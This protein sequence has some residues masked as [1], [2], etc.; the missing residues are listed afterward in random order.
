MLL[1]F[2][3]LKTFV[4]FTVNGIADIVALGIRRAVDVFGLLGAVGIFLGFCLDTSFNCGVALQNYL[5]RRPNFSREVQ[6]SC[7]PFFVLPSNFIK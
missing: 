3:L 2:A 4:T 6:L 5:P 1:V 7:L